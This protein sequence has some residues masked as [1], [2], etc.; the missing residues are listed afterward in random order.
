M[1]H[2]GFIVLAALWAL[3]ALGAPSP[4]R[5]ASYDD[6][7]LGQNTESQAC[8]GV[9][10]FE[11]AQTP[12][13]VDIYCGA[14]ESPSGSLHL[15]SGGADAAAL[16]AREC[17]GQAAI[18]SDADAITV[19]QV[20]CARQG[21]DTG[22]HK[23]GLI[24]EARG[25]IVYGS[26]YPSD[27]APLLS[28]ARVSLGV[29]KPGAPPPGSGAP[30]L[31][32]IAQVYPGGAP[33]QGAEFN[34]E[35][36][37]R[38]GYEQ[39]IA[40]SFGAADQD[41][42]EL[43]RSHQ[44]VA[45]DDQDGEAEILAE[46]GLNFS[47]SGRFQDAAD[48]FDRA[49][50]EAN[51]ANDPLLV[52]KI[53]NYRAT[54][55]LNQGHNAQALDQALAANAAR[56]QMFAPLVSG[57]GATITAAQ[58]RALE[59]RA[60]PNSTRALLAFLDEVSPQEKAAILSAQADDIAA[61]AARALGRPDA[62]HY[63][64][65]ALAELGQASTPPSWLAGQIYEERSALA[66]DRGDAGA[67]A[68]EAAEGLRQVR[69]LA[70]DTRIEAR[71]LLA[72][73]R[74][75]IAAGDLNGALAQGRAAVS[76]LER[77]SEAP[78]MPADEAATHINA[79]L[80]AYEQS[81]DPALAAEYFETLSLVW[82][83][84][85][86][87]AAAQ[88]AARLGDEQGGEAIR[89][90]QDAQ[91]AYRTAL[92]RRVRIAATEA[93]ASELA[94]AD[95]AAQAAGVALT[96]A[97]AQVRARSPRYLELLNPRVATSDLIKVLRPSEGYV[98][99]VLT[100]QGGF[101]ALVTKAGVTPYR[102]DLTEAV[103]G[104]LVTAIR[105]SSVIKGRRLPDY[106][107]DAAR[108]LYRSLFEPVQT[109]LD[110][111]QGLHIDGGGVLASLPMGAL[112]VT[113]P[114]QDMLQQIA[115][116]QD[117]SDVDWLARHHDLDTALG[118]AAFV[119]T[120]MEGGTAPIPSVMAFG[121]FDPDPVLAAQRIAATHGLSEHC[122]HEVEVALSALKAL[123]QTGPEARD[124]AAVFPSGQV[125]LGPDFTDEH[126]FKNADVADASI[127]V[128]ATHGVLGLSSCFAEPALLTSVGP[129]GDGLI[130][131][132]ELLNRALKARLVVLSACNTAGGTGASLTRT[133]LTD[134]G[135]ALS[136]LA[137][138]FIYAGA[139]IVLATQWPIDASSSA[140]QTDILLKTAAEPGH[141]VAEALGEAQRS[142][143]SQ[144]ETAHPFFW[145]GFD[146]IGDGGAVLTGPS[147]QAA[148]N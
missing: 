111:V 72:S 30:G 36:L 45:P 117:Y 106:D 31:S 129:E 21:G 131:A 1:T 57:G 114:S 56:N 104:R 69:E 120:R 125:S 124:A 42:S 74:A 4:S 58:T 118:P 130:E 144:A 83:G 22:P 128:L 110:S 143:Y 49:E 95:Q 65:E 99:V 132:S 82:D 48:L 32:Q 80:S 40:W 34:Y 81:K 92:A 18:V 28:A 61:V 62:G 5:A 121:D 41:F 15:V 137:R 141:T 17:G 63:L 79:L 85:A 9:W 113:D 77:Q 35:L 140:L 86:S 24:A 103:A 44:K 16:L 68:S 112:I 94:A 25:R 90:Y 47:D 148:A 33:G 26:V 66:L 142:L 122:R 73:E 8:R 64:D 145:S 101:G 55:E 67:A 3:I 146:L 126:F 115:L 127:L 139:P 76:I 107:L 6:F 102:I 75:K 119:R 138:A 13:A 123:P 11:S 134:G 116:D 27:W 87:R 12:T 54:N 50:A 19:R 29:D 51:E 100:E 109:E 70:P 53:A 14:W 46:I 39:N 37:R 10:R 38:R 43:L 84:S 147:T 93:Q 105:N 60:A 136:G 96:Q 59:V 89:A 71:L 2:R 88:L 52:T 135:E 98:R 78:G 23:F 133:G 20:S 7:S 97:E 108:H 91:T